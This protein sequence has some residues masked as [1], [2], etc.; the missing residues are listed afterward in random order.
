MLSSKKRSD[1]RFFE[2]EHFWILHRWIC[3]CVFGGWGR[4]KKAFSIL[5]RDARTPPGLILG[6]F[7]IFARGSEE[8]PS[9]LF[10][11]SA[12]RLFGYSAMQLFGYTA[13]RPC[14]YVAVRLF[15]YSFGYAVIQLFGYSAIRLFGYAAMRLF[16]YSAIRLFGH[17]AIRLYCYSAI[18]LFYSALRLGTNGECR[19]RNLLK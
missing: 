2:A 12:V 18:R 8:T 15:G 16:G 14:D 13:I 3:C 1:V 19:C 10:G 5:K 6:Y 7:R 9:R 11:Y 17:S 4:G